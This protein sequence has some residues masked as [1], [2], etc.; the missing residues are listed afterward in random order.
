MTNRECK[1]YNADSY[2]KGYER[3]S[4]LT[5][6]ELESYLKEHVL[7]NIGTS[8]SGR[9]Y[10]TTAGIFRDASSQ[11]TL[12]DL[13]EYFADHD[14]HAYTALSPYVMLTYNRLLSQFIQKCLSE[15]KSNNMLRAMEKKEQAVK[16][17][18]CSEIESHF[19]ETSVWNH[20]LN[21]DR[22]GRYSYCKMI[23]LNK[24]RSYN[25]HSE[26][27]EDRPNLIFLDQSINDEDGNSVTILDMTEDKKTNTNG[28]F[29][30]SE[31]A[32][33][34]LYA[35]AYIL[36]DDPAYLL[37]LFHKVISKSPEYSS[38]QES[39]RTNGGNYIWEKVVKNF[40]FLSD[41]PVS[42]SDLDPKDLTSK[43]LGSAKRK[44][45]L[46]LMKYMKD[47][48]HRE[49]IYDAYHSFMLSKKIRY[50]DTMTR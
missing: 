2:D 43:T 30:V 10:E 17:L 48:Y 38:L 47:E 3:I 18:V 9:F 49:D 1:L 19:R 40:S 46:A 15:G 13:Y 8:A 42:F 12:M 35:T 5:A 21:A 32:I 22:K 31:E 50:A 14:I 28:A 16:D 39:V 26:F 20:I 11:F 6:N 37:T 25:E 29:D 33:G 27:D 4:N 7:W 41:I 45:R 24:V 36:K 44:V 23:V 34:M